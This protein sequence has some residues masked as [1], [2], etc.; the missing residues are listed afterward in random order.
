M[1]NESMI[2]V[3]KISHDLKIARLYL[4]TD[5]WF[6]VDIDE[7]MTD[8]EIR[9]MLYEIIDGLPDIPPFSLVNKDTMSVDIMYEL[10]DS[11]AVRTYYVL[12]RQNVHSVDE[13][14]R[15]TAEQFLTFRN[16]GRKGINNLI[17]VFYELGYTPTNAMYTVQDYFETK[18]KEREQAESKE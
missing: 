2:V 12:K 16:L 17:L 15:L 8:F 18:R 7:P 1:E 10:C 4:G 13:I 6:D 9:R 11:M 5:P 3:Y 14:K